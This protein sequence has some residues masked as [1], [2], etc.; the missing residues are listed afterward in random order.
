MGERFRL[1]VCVF[2]LSVFHLGGDGDSGVIQ[3]MWMV[4]VDVAGGRT[5]IRG[6][7]KCDFINLSS[8]GNLLF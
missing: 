4:G 2:T 7:W 5:W 3:V 1:R 8:G 6:E